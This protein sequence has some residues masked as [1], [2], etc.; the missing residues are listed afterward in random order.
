MNRLLRLLVIA[1]VLSPAVLTSKTTLKAWPS[2]DSLTPSNES[3]ES[4]LKAA[5]AGRKVPPDLSVFYNDMH[6]LWGGKS[7]LIRGSGSGERRERSRRKEKPKVVKNTIDQGQL[8]ELIKLLIELR[9]WEQQ[10]AD[11]PPVPDESTATL[12]ISVGHRSS[13]LWERVNEMPRN[14]RLVKVK[15]RILEMTGGK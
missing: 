15:A 4:E 8:L 7:I 12:T 14:N 1:L 11:R 2:T 10:T 6:G 3:V 13:R 5:L 9:A